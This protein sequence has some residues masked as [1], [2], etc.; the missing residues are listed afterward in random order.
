LE[1]FDYGARAELFPLKSGGRPGPIGYVRFARA[2]DAIRYAIEQLSPKLLLGTYLEVG[3][4][5]FNGKGIREL[6]EN[7]DYPLSR[8]SANP[9][10]DGS[11]P[12]HNYVR[13]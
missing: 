13:N 7:V 1:T 3:E 10:S 8:R 12:K 11:E 6:Y 2:A 9:D 5:R 4:D